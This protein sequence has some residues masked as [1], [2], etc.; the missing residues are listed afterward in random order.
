MNLVFKQLQQLYLAG[1]LPSSLLLTSSNV[2]ELMVESLAF[3]KWLVCLNKN[4]V[5]ACDACHLCKLVQANTCPDLLQL[6]PE[7]SGNNKTLKIEQVRELIEF[8]QLKPQFSA[9]KIAI[10]TGAEYLTVQA[11]NALL[12]TLEE[13]PSAV[14]IMLLVT[15]PSLLITTI[16]SRCFLVNVKAS[17]SVTAVNE[18]LLNTLVEDIYQALIVAK[19]DVVTIVEKWLHYEILALLSALWFIL[20]ELVGK[21]YKLTCNYCQLTQEKLM[22][23][24]Q[25]QSFSKLWPI[26]DM[27]VEAR[28]LVIL[29]RSVNMQLLLE[30][31]IITWKYSIANDRK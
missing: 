10:I 2:A 4:E 18:E 7:Q 24:S 20:R 21:Q 13:P 11:A 8:V 1:K 6:Q 22:I 29:G 15:E 19:L 14:Y 31:F 28:S 23:I 30:K 26:I 12:K 5:T 17:N 9:G 16:R 27:I 25:R 3:A